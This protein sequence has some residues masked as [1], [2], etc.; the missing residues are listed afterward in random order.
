M[1]LRNCSASNLPGEHGLRPIFHSKKERTEGYLFISLLVDRFVP[2]SRQCLHTHGITTFWA[3]RRETLAVQRRVS[4][5][6]T[7]RDSR[8]RHVREAT[9]SEPDLVRF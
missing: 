7:R 1:N 5:S 4:A 9:R 2:S 6:I 3:Q 8:T